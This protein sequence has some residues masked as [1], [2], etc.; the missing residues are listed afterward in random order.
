[1]KRS[2][3]YFLILVTLSFGLFWG[4]LRTLVSQSLQYDHYSH[5]LVVPVISAGFIYWID[6]HKIFQN[7]CPCLRGAALL[8]ALAAGLYWL[9]QRHSPVSTSGYF[10]LAILSIVFFWMA[11][12]LLF[13]GPQAFRASAFPLS[14]LLLMVPFPE[15]AL[16]GIIH[17]LQQGSADVSYVLFSMTGVPVFREGF[18]FTL[19]GLTIEVAEECSGI[20]SSIA[21]FILCLLIGHLFLR[22]PSRKVALIVAAIPIL[23]FKNAVRI[24]TISLLSIYVSRDFL[25]GSLHKSGGVLFFLLGLLILIP[26]IR[27]LERSENKLA[28]GNRRD[29]AGC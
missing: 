14:F 13:Y 18:F 15:F 1:M 29:I 2:D 9:A 12:F 27:L 11:G 17:A 28:P 8:F 5:I 10:P 20:R 23:L 16:A 24:V 26:L 25:T 21:L 3:F 22:S 19:P 6:R 7:V 4:P